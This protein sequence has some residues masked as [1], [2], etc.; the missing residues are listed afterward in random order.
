VGISILSGGLVTRTLQRCICDLELFQN[1]EH[2]RQYRTK[3][4]A[5]INANH[6]NFGSTGHAKFEITRRLTELNHSGITDIGEY[7]YASGR[8]A[9]AHAGTSPTVDPEN[10]EDIERLSKDF[11]VI[12]AMA[13][14][15]IE[16]ELEV[17]SSHTVW[18]GHLYELSG[19]K[20]LLGPEIAERLKAK[21]NTLQPPDAA[22]IHRLRIGVK[23]RPPYTALKALTVRQAT[24]TDGKLT[25]LT[26]SEDGLIEVDLTLDFAAER[27]LFD[28]DNGLRA[29][30]DGSENSAKQIVSVL[31]FI[32]DYVGNGK[33]QVFNS[34]TGSLLGRKDAYIPMNIIPGLAAEHF[35]QLITQYEAEAETRAAKAN[36]GGA[37]A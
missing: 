20:D 12:R 18:A 23:N 37:M 30:D 26:S 33:L 8:C 4:K 24:I 11:P 35:G 27:M 32:S 16:K 22:A 10:P 1:I 29:S 3:A 6:A 15:V 5:W 36:Q 17:K 31:H 28:I 19:F 21:D 14:H 2:H 34:E 13:A 9:I 7:L 25:L